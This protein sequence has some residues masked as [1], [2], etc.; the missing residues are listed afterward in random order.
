MQMP[1]ELYALT[2]TCEILQGRRCDRHRDVDLDVGRREFYVQTERPTA[3]RDD[4]VVSG[5]VR[6]YRSFHRDCRSH[7]E[8]ETFYDLR[9]SLIT[10]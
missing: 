9:E 7:G 10:E 5:N 1:F 6:T 3:L 8:K 2:E 4:L